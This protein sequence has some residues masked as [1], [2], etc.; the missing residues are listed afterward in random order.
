MFRKWIVTQNNPQDW[1]QSLQNFWDSGKFRYVCGQLEKAPSTGTLHLQAYLHCFESMRKPT[2]IKMN[3]VAHFEPVLK[4]NGAAAYAKKEDSREE[5]PLEFGEPPATKSEAAKKG[6]EA[7]KER[8]K[9][10]M[11]LGALNALH[12][13]L[14]EVKDYDRLKKCIG[15]IELDMKKLEAAPDVR[16]IWIYGEP[17]IG[18]SHYAR[19]TW[20]DPFVKG[21]NK[22]WDGFNGE[23]FVLI[24]DFDKNGRVLGHHIKI[25]ADKW[26][27]TGEIKGG[28]VPLIY[29]KFIITSNYL[30]EDIWGQDDQ[31]LVRAI[32]RRFK[33][34]HAHLDANGNRQFT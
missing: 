7:R 15:L 27:C 10:I 33:F 12:E 1:R 3:A 29:D 8:N 11:E 2:L 5:G 31:E 25:W 30:P 20:A 24:D 13:G 9:I 34:I 28:T 22:W 21:Q 6:V 32:N 14:L 17:G 19:E 23:K 4:D 16:G 18:K 26:G